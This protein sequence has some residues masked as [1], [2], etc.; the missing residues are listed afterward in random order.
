MERTAAAGVVRSVPGTVTEGTVAA[1]SEGS[2]QA[3][4]L[5]V[6]GRGVRA[7]MLV[8]GGQHPLPQR[9]KGEMTYCC[10]CVRK[11][12][13][14]ESLIYLRFELEEVGVDVLAIWR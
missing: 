12:R 4:G 6:V 7:K 9:S 5:T 3:D 8:D 1:E 2:T 10:C 13:N 14:Y 11:V